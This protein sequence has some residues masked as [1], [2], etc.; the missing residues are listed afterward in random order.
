MLHTPTYG[1]DVAAEGRLIAA[2]VREPFASD[3][4]AVKGAAPFI[5]SPT[6][7][8]QQLAAKKNP[9]VVLENA[10]ILRQGMTGREKEK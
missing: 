3:A 1:R 8:F 10:L 6:R 5:S 7:V 4:T 2:F 9:R